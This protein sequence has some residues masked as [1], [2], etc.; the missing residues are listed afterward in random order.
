MPRACAALLGLFAAV[1]LAAA[2]ARADDNA[3]RDPAYYR[4]RV[5]HPPPEDA[6]LWVPRVVF[7]PLH[8]VSEYVLRRPLVAA[9]EFSETHHLIASADHGLNPTPNFS[10]SP[11]LLVDLGLR[12]SVGV[13]LRVRNAFVPSNELRAAVSTGGLDFWHVALRQRYSASTW[14]I[15][16]L[17]D[18]LTRPDRPFY[19]LLNTSR[20]EN[21]T[22]Y[23][24]TR[25]DALLQG[26]YAPSHRAQL[27]LAGGYRLSDTGPGLT[28]SLETIFNAAAI[29]GYGQTLHLAIARAELALDSRGSR[30][31]TT[32]V[33]LRTRGTYGLD[34]V[35][36]QR[37]WVALEV[38]AEGALE[39]MAPHRVVTLS[40]YAMDTQPLGTEP[41]PF[42]EQATLGFYRLPGFLWGRFVGPS[43]AVLEASYRYPIWEQLD[44]VWMAGAGNVFGQHLWDFRPGSLA[45]SFALGFRTRDEA[46]GALELLVAIGTSRF[47]EPFEVQ[48]VRLHVG[49][50]SGL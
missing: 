27:Q 30:Q 33:W 38:E 26:G 16:V 50:N 28:P 20:I 40:A 7:F 8:V 42:T 9:I 18:F 43:A 17:A 12:T 21:L 45:G 44:A 35:N 34:M 31:A 3:R 10:W 23:R 11:T 14:Y 13:Q 37:Q 39:V 46:H 49:V 25:L 2:P 48:S 19:G 24:L 29:P 32:G 6:A 41:V 5:E 47:D 1:L 15:G 4:G 36:T 22:Y